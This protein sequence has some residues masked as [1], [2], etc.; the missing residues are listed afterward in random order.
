MSIP[1][2]LVIVSEKYLSTSFLLK[3]KHSKICA[4]L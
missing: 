4:P 2:I 1:S 3:P